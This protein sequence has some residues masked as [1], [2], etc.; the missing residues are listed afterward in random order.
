MREL[1][2]LLIPLA[3]FLVGVLT[4]EGQPSL[5]EGAKPYTPS[6]LEWLALDMEVRSRPETSEGSGFSMHFV[7][8]ED[9]DTIRIDVR[10]S[11]TVNREIINISI[12]AAREMITIHSKANGWTSWLKIK[13]DVRMTK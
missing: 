7:P 3:A 12:S 4:P 9:S 11:P 5:L 1:K 13:E 2:K 10:Y 6:R 8:L